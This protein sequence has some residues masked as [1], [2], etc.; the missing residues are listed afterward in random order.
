MSRW[1]VFMI[2]YA[3][4]LSVGVI[5]ASVLGKPTRDT[6]IVESMVWG[7]ACAFLMQKE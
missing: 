1:K 2:G 7:L 4:W 3:V 6:L 5:F